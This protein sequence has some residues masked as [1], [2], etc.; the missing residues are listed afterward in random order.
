VTDTGTGQVDVT[1]ATDFSSANYAVTCGAEH[2]SAMV[3]NV[4]AATQAVGAFQGSSYDVA[5]TPTDPT[6]YYFACFGDQ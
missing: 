2:N 4:T 6:N 3:I 5:G 1:I